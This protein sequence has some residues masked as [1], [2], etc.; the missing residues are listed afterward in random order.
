MIRQ[1]DIV[2]GAIL[3]LCIDTDHQTRLLER[4][5]DFST[6]YTLA[7]IATQYW[8]NEKKSHNILTGVGNLIPIC[9]S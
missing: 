7:P 9:G 2:A 3:I 6:G 4:Q 8:G 1:G 5:P